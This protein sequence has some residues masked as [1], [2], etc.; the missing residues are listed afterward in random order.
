MRNIHQQIE[1]VERELRLRPGVYQR[2][3][4]RGQLRQAEADEHMA[5]LE[6]ALE[7]LKWCRDNRDLLAA[8]KSAQESQS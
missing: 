6:A 5:R 7:T 1:E 8:F 3:V 4:G 2:L